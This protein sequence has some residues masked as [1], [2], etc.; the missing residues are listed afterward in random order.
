MNAMATNAG[1]AT[2]NRML[3]RLALVL[4]VL[5]A[6]W[7][8]LALARYLRQD[9]TVSL[10]IARLD[11]AAVDSV[12]FT[13]AAD[14]SRVARGAKGAWTV[15]GFPASHDAVGGLLRGFADTAK[16]T[17]LVAES[18]ASHARLGIDAATGQRVRVVSHGK[19][20]LDLTTGKQASDYASLLVRSTDAE[21]V[22]AL[23]GPL[24]DA[25]NKTGDDWRDKR[26]IT[27]EADSIGT[28]EVARGSRA[29]T[30]RRTDKGP[31]QFASGSA[32]DPT[33]MQ[34][35]IGAYHEVMASGFATKA[36][37]DSIDFKRGRGHLRLLSRSGKPLASV[38]FDST[39]T[40]FWLRPE[41]D[42]VVY[43]IEPYTWNAIAPAE[44]T[45]KVKAPAKTPTK[46]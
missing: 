9:K 15:N 11:T 46:K 8:L 25:L 14:T 3:R 34:T 10:A 7:G 29:Y 40:G 19:T 18:K 31:W 13:R 44:S 2:G 6:I 38:L 5:V 42:S 21:Q 32:A 45:L 35:L 37:R 27:A 33:A 36:D 20:L 30:V 24:A 1:G 28:I 12:I 4:I 23:H 41:A 16:S 22:Y 26:L 43:R 39:K 17:E